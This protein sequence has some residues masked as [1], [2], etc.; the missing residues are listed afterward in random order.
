MDVFPLLVL[1]LVVIVLIALSVGVYH[2]PRFKM[3]SYTQGRVEQSTVREV[4]TELE[5]YE[6]TEIV[7]GYHVV[8]QSHRLTKTVPGNH[9][10]RYPIGLPL[11]VHYNP[12]DPEMARADDATT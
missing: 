7:V 6:Q 11:R 1:I 8:G 10:A 5:R 12:S 4:R 9:A 3:T 2:R